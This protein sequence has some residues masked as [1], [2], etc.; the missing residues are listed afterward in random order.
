MGTPQLSERGPGLLSDRR[1]SL[2]LL[3]IRDPQVLYRLTERGE[4]DSLVVG[5][6]SRRWVRSSL[7]A[8]IDRQVEANR[9][10]ETA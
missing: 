3:G 6:R 1:E 4:V 5:E 7:L 10:G 2:A 8:Y 9:L